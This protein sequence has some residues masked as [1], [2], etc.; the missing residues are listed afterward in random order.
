M[1]AI[2]LI[3]KRRGGA[4]KY[5]WLPFE[6]SDDYEREDWWDSPP[7]L[8]DDP[9]FLQALRSG[10]EVGRVHLVDRK[11]WLSDSYGVDPKIEALALQI[12]LIE[13]PYTHR[14]QHIGTDIVR[15]LVE[16]HPNRRLVAFSEGADDFWTKL[17]GGRCYKHLTDPD[18]QLLFIADAP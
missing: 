10:N 16:R 7:Y 17:D 8:E 14:R 5:T 13:V 18:C 12:H 3:E 2:E 4:D 1:A 9:L 11:M 6:S 15:A